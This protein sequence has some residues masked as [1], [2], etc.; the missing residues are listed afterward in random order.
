MR[1]TSFRTICPVVGG[2]VLEGLARVH[3]VDAVVVE[4]REVGHRVVAVA[5]RAEVGVD[6][7]GVEPG[8][9]D[10]V[11][12]VGVQI[13]DRQFLERVGVTE[14]VHGTLG[15]VQVRPADVDDP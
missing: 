11:A 8:P 14:P 15:P 6:P 3:E 5:D 12:L 7:V 10:D 1:K 13:D 2:D 9:V 4:G